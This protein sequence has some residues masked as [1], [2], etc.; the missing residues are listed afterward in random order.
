[1]LLAP[2][3]FTQFK[4]NEVNSRANTQAARS[5]S[6]GGPIPDDFFAGDDRAQRGTMALRDVDYAVEAE[7]VLTLAPARRII[8]GSSKRC[9]SAVSNAASSTCSPIWDAAS[10]PPSSSRTPERRR[11]LQAKPVRSASC[12]TT[13]ASRRAATKR[14]S[15]MPAC[16]TAPSMCPNGGR[17]DSA[18]AEGTGR[19]E[20]LTADLDYEPKLVAWVISLDEAG[21]YLGVTSTAMPQGPKGKLLP[22]TMQIPRA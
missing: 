16:A 4:R 20:G 3:R 14:F 15:S 18:I 1:M 17:H 19:A 12:S 21:R 13:S 9:S 2:V 11:P 6:R 22:K 7:I 10:S 8:S 5:A